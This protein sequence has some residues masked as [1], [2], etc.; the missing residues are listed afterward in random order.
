MTVPTKTT[1]T[2]R[3]P[4]PAL[5]REDGRLSVGMGWE[6]SRWELSRLA[7]ASERESLSLK[8]VSSWNLR[9][10][11]RI[12]KWQKHF[13]KLWDSSLLWTIIYSNCSD[14]FSVERNFL[15]IQRSPPKM[16]STSFSS[17]LG[18]Q[19]I[20]S[21]VA[22]VGAHH[23]SRVL[24]NPFKAPCTRSCYQSLSG[25]GF[26][27]QLP[28]S[29]GRHDASNAGTNWKYI[30]AHHLVTSIVV[31]REVVFL[32]RFR[33]QIIQLV[34]KSPAQLAGRFP[35][36]ISSSAPLIGWFTTPSQVGLMEFCPSTVSPFGK[37]TY[38]YHG[39]EDNGPSNKTSRDGIPS[40]DVQEARMNGWDHQVI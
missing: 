10:V 3:R 21:K 7:N 40:R 14:N 19:N 24:G 35:T 31:K 37:K 11:G 36:E 6:G 20:F 22:E 12:E 17:T 5:Q 39:N 34:V 28:Y 9:L 33:G 29:Y 15:T 25:T 16:T 13:S 27:N 26:S 18:C 38:P 30:A 32:L 8:S 2:W 23:T 1:W 4:P